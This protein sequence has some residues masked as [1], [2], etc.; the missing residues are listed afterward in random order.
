MSDT[1]IGW[2]V[3]LG[4]ALAM[5]ARTPAAALALDDAP[6]PSPF[7]SMNYDEALAAAAESD[8]PLLVYAT[9]V[10]CGPCRIMEQTTWVDERVVERLR[11]S[12]VAIK[13]DVDEEPETAR[14]L[15][16]RAMPTMIVF[17]DGEEFDRKVGLQTAEQMLEWLDGVERGERGVDALRRRIAEH[18]QRDVDIEARLTLAQELLV[19]GDHEHSTREYVWLWRN[20]LDHD[21]AY[22][23]VRVSF[24]ASSMKELSEMHEPAA[25]AFGAIRDEVE[26][27]LRS[28]EAE[29]SHLVDWVTLNEVVGDDERTLAWFDRVKDDPEAEN[30]IYRVRTRLERVLREHARWADLGSILANPVVDA[31]R[32]LATTRFAEHPPNGSGEADPNNRGWLARRHAISELSLLYGACLAAGREDE[33]NEVAAIL[34]DAAVEPEAKLSLVGWAVHV[35][36]IRPVHREWLDEVGD[37]PDAAELRAA[38]E[39]AGASR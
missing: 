38:V 23:G 36:E 34:L 8:T 37:H 13:L 3:F 6:A 39:D 32:T 17:V 24:M 29:M 26:A 18:E 1:R 16:V 12:M 28:D 21:P 30:S 2:M 9:A 27:I 19:A 14:K 7:R 20:M 35:G 5:I 10:W 4:I 25:E 15:A 31:R 11:D 22:T 33:A